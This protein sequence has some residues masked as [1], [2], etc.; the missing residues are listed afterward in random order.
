MEHIYRPTVRACFTGYVVQAILNS[1]TPLLLVT[2][3]E[4]YGVSLS[5]ITLLVTVNF[6]VQLLV[7]LL[8]VGLVDALGCRAAALLAH[9]LSVAGLAALTVLPEWMPDPFQGLF[10][11]VVLYAAG[12]GLLEVLVSPIVEACPSDNKEKAMSLLHASYCWGQVAVVAVS[13]LFFAIFGVEKWR[14]LTRLWAILPAV[15][16]CRFLSV[17]LPPLLPEGEKGQSA[18]ALLRRR[19]FWVL[20]LMMLCA[21][22]CEQA[23]AQ[24]A[25]AFAEK[26]L[27]LGKALGDLAGPML[28]AASMGAVRTLY[29]KM[30]ER[31][32][33]SR[34]MLGG[35]VLCA[36]G[37]FLAA[38]APWPLLGLIGCTLCGLSVGILW[39]GTYSIASGTISRG[40]TTMFALLALAGDLGCAG[41]PALVG[42]AS[43]AGDGDLRAGL[44]AAALFPVILTAAIVLY[45]RTKK[46]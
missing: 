36:A 34:F 2:F 16:L 1:L 29:G 11:A 39:P 27:G 31:W 38:L 7:D 3:Q 8:S 12:G 17:P 13:T 37:Y 32:D 19:L 41:G 10:L 18:G 35:S 5:R 6:I 44:L 24:W 21:G 40:G 33:L 26:G 46:P 23:V 14:V 25:S 42:L 20:M 30:G 28:F 9:G 4:Q 22:A 15:N 45:R 43:G